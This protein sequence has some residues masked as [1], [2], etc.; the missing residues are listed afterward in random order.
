MKVNGK[1]DIPH[2]MEIYGKIIQ[3]FQTTNQK[4]HWT[5]QPAI[6]CCPRVSLFNGDPQ[7]STPHPPDV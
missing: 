6:F 2:S 7:D 5:K 3:M 1:D 4:K